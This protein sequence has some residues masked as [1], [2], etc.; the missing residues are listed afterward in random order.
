MVG[1]ML[2]LQ[3]HV[4]LGT[5]PFSGVFSPV[6]EQQAQTIVERF[7]ELGGVY[8]DTAPIYGFG[9]VENSLGRF[10]NNTPRD[11]YYITTKCGIIWAPDRRLLISGRYKDVLCECESSLRRLGLDY[12]DLYI[13]H[14]PDPDTPHEETMAALADLQTQGKIREI[15]LSN[16]SLEQ[17][18]KYNKTR[19]VRFVQNRFSLLNQSFDRL[20]VDY[21]VEHGIGLTPY[22]VIERG[23]LTD[24]MVKSKNHYM[25]ENDLRS[26]KPEFSTK[27]KQVITSWVAQSLQPIAESLG[28]SVSTLAIWWVLQ[29]PAVAFCICGATKETQIIENLGATMIAPPKDTLDQINAT[30]IALANAI[31]SRDSL[32]IR[33]FMGVG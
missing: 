13:L 1:Q 4:G 11:K 20:F 32:N 33:E 15:G 26:T 12:I 31:H 9:D 29:Q 23:L 6:N 17:L 28:V 19:L 16:V 22:Q 24:Q 14:V 8:I 2:A 21:C 18:Q 7:L 10:L 3:S 25:N 30:Y 5:F 27:V